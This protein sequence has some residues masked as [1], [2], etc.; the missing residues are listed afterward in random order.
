MNFPAIPKKVYIILLGMAVFLCLGVIIAWIY[1]TDQ[2]RREDPRVAPAR[3]MLVSFDDLMKKQSFSK[4]ESLL[5]TIQQ[6]YAGTP[7]YSQSFEMAML[8]NNRASIYLSRALYEIP[9][10]DSSSRLHFLTV[11][12]NFENQSI[13]F[14]ERW[15]REYDPL[16]EKE[17]MSKIIPCFQD[18][19][20]AFIGLN[21][22]K[23]RKK[24]LEDLVAAKSENRKRLSVA[25]TN[26]GTI[27]RHLALP[28]SALSCYQ[29]ALYLWPHNTT[30][31]NNLNHLMGKDQPVSK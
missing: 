7:G 12:K 3:K 1:F 20:P 9:S 16:G 6:I 22:K 23:I 28:D 26:L 4:A 29:T 14:Y 27:M 24:R 30:A 31:T 17:I 10:Q 25:Y 21:L 18:D 2:N 19:D 11:A 8:L 5:D 15:I 13:N